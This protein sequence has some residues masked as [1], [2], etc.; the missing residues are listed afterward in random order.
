MSLLWSDTGLPN[1]T[2]NYQG[3]QDSPV[4]ASSM[5][6]G[7]IRRRRRFARSQATMR[8][9]WL[10]TNEQY[11]IFKGFFN[12]TTEGGDIYFDI[13]LPGEENEGTLTKVRFAEGGW[14]YSYV[15][16]N[17]WRVTATL[18]KFTG[19][20]YADPEVELTPIFFTPEIALVSDI[21]ALP[22]VHK[23][24]LMVSNPGTGV[25]KTITVPAI[26]SA[27]DY[28]P[29]GVMLTGAGSVTIRTEGETSGPG[30]APDPDWLAYL[31]TQ[32]PWAL[33]DGS[34]TVQTAGSVTQ[35]TDLSGN[36]RH[37]TDA[38]T[39]TS[40]C[41]TDG[42][43]L[44][45]TEGGRSLSATLPSG[46]LPAK[47][48]AFIL[49]KADADLIAEAS[50]TYYVL[51]PF[52]A[53]NSNAYWGLNINTGTWRSVNAFAGAIQNTFRNPLN[54]SKYILFEAV[55]DTNSQHGYVN[56]AA[57]WVNP[58]ATWLDSNMT[59]S[60]VRI[61]SQAGNFNH[62]SGLI[63]TMVIFSTVSGWLTRN[64]IRDIRQACFD[65]F[66]DTYLSPSL[67]Q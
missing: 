18:E 9:S 2:Q 16:H 36:S 7:R 26:A 10:F 1:P 52:A 15:P 8:V 56:G 51:S 19:L 55:R 47:F 24:A 63:K 48:H 65:E 21:D 34:T 41:T 38:Q 50:D 35:W 62:E 57:E 23:N 31:L 39:G 59:W 3:L 28:L 33:Y 6:S 17:R 20:V 43:H 37:L 40:R 12:T 58:G 42:V 54:A 44:V 22:S 5:E 27:N 60:G 49:L 61:G 13:L 29:I 67:K 66:P 11:T 46:T 53:S 64:Q 30:P 14:N 45:T 32:A 25:T 4:I